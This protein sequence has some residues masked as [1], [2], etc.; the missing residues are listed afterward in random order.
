MV[1]LPDPLVQAKANLTCI[2]FAGKILYDLA[3]W[4]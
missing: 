1:D 2:N 4:S 3:V